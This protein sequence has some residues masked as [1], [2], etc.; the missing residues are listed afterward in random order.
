MRAALP[1]LR[2]DSAGR[3]EG[4]AWITWRSFGWDPTARLR[5]AGEVNGMD[6]A[7]T[8]TYTSKRYTDPEPEHYTLRL[9][10]T[11]DFSGIGCL[12]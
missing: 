11:P 8:V 10:A 1:E 2:L 6:M 5:V 9:G 4:T 12:L 7:L 3:F